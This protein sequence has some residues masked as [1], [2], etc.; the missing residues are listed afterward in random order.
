VTIDQRMELALAKLA[1]QWGSRR[2]KAFYLNEADWDEFMAKARETCVVPFG[3]NPVEQ[4]EDP[5][6]KDI[7]VR[8]STAKQSRLYDHTTTGRPI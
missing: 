2:P 8:Q 4:R 6:F 5:A 3:N 7:P 1:E